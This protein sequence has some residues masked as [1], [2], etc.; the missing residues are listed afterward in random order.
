MFVLYG[1]R[2]G[3][4]DWSVF[5]EGTGG[6]WFMFDTYD[7]DIWEV[8]AFDQGYTT[9]STRLHH[10]YTIQHCTIHCPGALFQEQ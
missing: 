3:W 4:V 1:W 7:L 9:G 10:G 2:L 6:D 8:K 5:G